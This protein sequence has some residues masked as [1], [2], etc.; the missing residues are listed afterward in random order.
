MIYVLLFLVFTTCNGMFRSQQEK[1]IIIQRGNS[2]QQGN[3]FITNNQRTCN[4]NN[5]V[6][7]SPI[8]KLGLTQTQNSLSSLPISSKYTRPLFDFMGRPI[9]TRESKVLRKNK[10]LRLNQN[11][12]GQFPNVNRNRPF[13]RR[14]QQS[15][16]NFPNPFLS[17]GFRND[18]KRVRQPSDILRRTQRLKSRGATRTSIISSGARNAG[19]CKDDFF[20][21]T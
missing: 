12:P 5:A 21:F 1:Q 16:T 8:I 11:L 15:F 7:N 14:T 9:L 17:Q 3:S 18:A 2:N 20:S 10:S 19:N 6:Q 4:Q 13:I